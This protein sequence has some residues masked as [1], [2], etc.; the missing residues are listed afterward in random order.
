VTGGLGT[1]QSKAVKMGLGALMLS[2][3]RFEFLKLGFFNKTSHERITEGCYA[4]FG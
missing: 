4:K 3:I 2:L 1:Q